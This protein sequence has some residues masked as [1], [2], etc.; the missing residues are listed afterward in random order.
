MEILITLLEQFLENHA[1][2]GYS[3][4]E[5][6]VQKWKTFNQKILKVLSFNQ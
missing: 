4:M 3:K 1:I 6:H 2:I 5:N